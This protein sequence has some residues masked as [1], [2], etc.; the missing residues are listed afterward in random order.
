MDVPQ[1][2]DIKKGKIPSQTVSIIKKCS[3]DKKKKRSNQI[4]NSID[5]LNFSAILLNFYASAALISLKEV[6]TYR[7]LWKK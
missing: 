3:R 5:L 6:G 7:D 1:S 2:K 4:R